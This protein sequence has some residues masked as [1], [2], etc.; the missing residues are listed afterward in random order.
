MGSRITRTELRC[1]A[2]PETRINPDTL[3]DIGAGGASSADS[4]YTQA[5]AR[6][7]VPTAGQNTALVLEATG[8]QTDLEE[9]GVS[10]VRAG[11]PGPD[12]AGLVVRDSADSLEWMGWEGFQLV[13]GWEPI[14]TGSGAAGGGLPSVLRM[15]GGGVLLAH[16]EAGAGSDGSIAIHRYDPST[17][18][19]SA[20]TDATFTATFGALPATPLIETPRGVLLYALSPT[21]RNLHLAIS[22]NSGTA[23]VLRAHDVLRTGLPSGSTVNEVCAAYNDGEVLLLVRYDSGSAEEVAQYASRD[24]GITF[25]QVDSTWDIA[26]DEPQSVAVVALK[27]GGFLVGYNDDATTNRYRSIRVGSAYESVQA[28]DSVVIVASD[29]GGTPS[30]AM[31]VD[32]DGTTYAVLALDTGSAYTTSL[33]RTIDG[34]ASWENYAGPIANLSPAAQDSELNEF[35]CT[36]TGGL[37]LLLA[38]YTVSNEDDASSALVCVYLGGL[39]TATVPATDED[40]GDGGAAALAFKD[41][42]FASWSPSTNNGTFG[43]LYLAAEVPGNMG[44]TLAGAAAWSI[45]ADLE[46]EAASPTPLSAYRTNTDD[47]VTGAILEFSANTDLTGTT[48]EEAAVRL[49]LS[50][51]DGSPGSASFTYAISVRFDATGWAVYDTNAGTSIGS[52]TVDMGTGDTEVRIRV[53]LGSSGRV[54]SWHSTG[55]RQETTWVDGPNSAGVTSTPADLPN[56]IDFGSWATMDDDA[57]WKYV[58]FNFW[59]SRWS[60]GSTADP[61]TEFADAAN[62]GITD[63]HPL[64]VSP[65][66]YLIRDG[67]LLHA[68]GGPA[69]YGDAWTV[70]PA[71]NYPLSAIFPSIDP[72]PRRGWRSTADNVEQR[73]TFL[74]DSDFGATRYLSNSLAVALLESNIETATLDTSPDGTNWTTIA[75]YDSTEG[76]TGLQ[77]DRRGRAVIPNPGGSWSGS[78]YVRHA[79]HVGDTF[80][81]AIGGSDDLHL[82]EANSEGAW[83]AGGTTKLPSLRLDDANMPGGLGDTNTGTGKLRRRSAVQVCSSYNDTDQYVRLRIPAHETAEGYYRIGTLVIG[84]LV[85]FGHQYDRGWSRSFEGN[86]DLHVRRDGVTHSRYRGP[87]R[88]VWEMAW[89]ETAIEETPIRADEPDPDWVSLQTTTSL[90][91]ATPHD[92]AHLLR[93]LQTTQRAGDIPVLFLP[94]VVVDSSDEQTP[95]VLLWARASSDVRAENL[96][97]DEDDSEM[98]RVSTITLRQEL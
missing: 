78:N 32:E 84:H 90:P 35:A 57:Y 41:T 45:T 36:S 67:T 8:D 4:S 79:A 58:G 59:G 21:G 7:G 19:W 98:S 22:T 66:P 53:A 97:G 9:L 6:A 11:M 3:T 25:D 10:I 49:V 91:L 71:Y 56:R 27:G 18:A 68:V 40:I 62:A 87:A 88:E 17:G 60:A 33:F 89:A 47:W 30:V 12:G 46:L 94:R 75:N 76:W 29:P 44:W 43:G 80:D 13:T 70:S 23:F 31:W 64:P 37:G 93:G 81:L 96:L 50:D 15:E 54:Q 26:G 42:A 16:H 5:G 69:V 14:Y 73:F 82:I 92:I 28:A 86:T 95:R 63:L 48:T 85:A 83:V 51:Y 52:A 61:D 39:S 20:L 34:G 72:S 55:G 38:R 2:I 24:G 74:L 77:Y 1:I 65:Y